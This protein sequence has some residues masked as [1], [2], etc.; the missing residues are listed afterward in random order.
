MARKRVLVQAGHISPREP[1]FEGGT[2]TV[3]EQEL[4]RAL[5]SR[6]LG[7]FKA[8][9]RFEAIAAP[10]D[11]PDGVTVDAAIFLHGDGSKNKAATGYSFGF[12]NF[13]INKKLADLIGA[14]F[15]K[16]P[17]HPPHHADNYTG[18]LRKYY[19]YSRVE[20]PGPEVLVEHGF[21]T[22]PA[23]QKW[24]FSHLNELA[25]AEYRAVCKFFGLAP[26]GQVEP[27]PLGWRVEAT[28]DAGQTR[29]VK[30][31]DKPRRILDRLWADGFRRKVLIRKNIPIPGRG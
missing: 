1:G 2:G 15:Q 4:T 8:D 28:N 12:P 25:T 9:D 24:I 18:G 31:T 6:L 27:K 10:G 23:E 5:R 20:T 3:R 11:I 30:K 17:G 22:N 29:I 21:L 19:G 26:Q 7:L 16:I 14:E 13:A